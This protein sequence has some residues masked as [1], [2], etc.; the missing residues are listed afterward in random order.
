MNKINVL[1]IGN[2]T[3]HAKLFS[4]FASNVF[5]AIDT[6]Y[7]VFNRLNS[8]RYEYNIIDLKTPKGLL[9]K[10]KYIKTLR[11]IVKSNSIDIIFTNTKNDLLFSKIAFLFARK[12]PLI[13]STLHNSLAWHNKFKNKMMGLTIK[14]CSDG[15]ICLCKRVYDELVGIVGKKK[16]LLLPNVISCEKSFKK[17]TYDITST[18][19]IVYVAT[20]YPNKNQS[21]AID[22]IEKISEKFNVEFHCIGDVIDKAYYSY[23]LSRLKEKGLENVF[24]FDGPVS[25]EVLLKEKLNK[26]DLYF[27]PSK[28][29][30]SPVNIL[31]AKSCGLPIV[32]SH[33][34]GQQDLIK[35]ME[36][37]VLYD[38][39]NLESAVSKIV[40]IIES[41]ELR[42]KLG[43]SARE[44]CEK[45][46]S[47]EKFSK[48]MEDFL[49]NICKKRSQ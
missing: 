12:R 38:D 3:R 21:F 7:S 18:I 17:A 32:A 28:M 44:N 42:T 26:F 20:I 43:C 48:K 27:S 34:F 24:I 22:V 47:C 16:L 13:I 5:L 9:K 23:L 8:E 49:L 40:Q 10:C 2:N 11:Q 39:E 6:E 30:M 14:I 45:H 15:F 19:K 1:I 46:Y 35:D 25:N 29:E 37:G 31:E 33:A 41:K 36:D 4:Y